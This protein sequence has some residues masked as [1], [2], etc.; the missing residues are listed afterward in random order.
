MI[1]KKSAYMTFCLGLVCIADAMAFRNCDTPNSHAWS[2]STH[3]TVGEIAFDGT[4]GLASGTETRYNYSNHY[5]NG[6]SECHVT[7]ELSGSYDPVVEVFTF[8]GTRSNYSDSC[9][10]DMLGVEYPESR[11]YSL[12][13]EFAEDGSAIVSAA[14]SGESIAS[15]SWDTGRATYKIGEQCTIF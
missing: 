4:T 9:P 12:Q 3:Y 6:A 2:A 15:G 1:I 8:N 10:P 13:M 14:E 5:S 11:L 7:Y